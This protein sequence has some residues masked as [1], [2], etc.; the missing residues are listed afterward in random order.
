M[1]RNKGKISIFCQ[2]HRPKQEQQ[3]ILKSMLMFRMIYLFYGIPQHIIIILHPASDKILSIN[4]ELFS[5]STKMSIKNLFL[6]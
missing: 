6:G 3:L 1:L 2:P 4:D 5:F